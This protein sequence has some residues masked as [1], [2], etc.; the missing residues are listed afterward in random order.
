MRGENFVKALPPDGRLRY[1]A[2]WLS[3]A[4]AEDLFR[5][6]ADGVEWQRSS[7][8]LF[9]REVPQPRRIAFQG[10]PGVRYRYSG[11]TWEAESWT[12]RVAALRDRL[13]EET[14]EGFNSVLLN[15]YRDGSDSMGWHADDEKELGRDPVIASVS[16]GATR[17]FRLRSRAKPRRSLALELEPGSL[18]LMSGDLQHAWQHALPKTRRAVGPRI[19]LTFRSVVGG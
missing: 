2:D 9:G 18:L 12:P 3:P 11:Q 15:L 13:V 6:L 16:L 4:R 1:V 8:R 14:G 17:R 5:S 7:V 19:N 10:D